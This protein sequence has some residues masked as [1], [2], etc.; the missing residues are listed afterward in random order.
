M[1]TA[2][3]PVRPRDPH[4]AVKHELLVRYLDAW[5][6]TV[7]HSARRVTYAEG[8]A[9][10]DVH[11]DGEGGSSVTALRVFGEFTDRLAGRQLAMV[12]V[13]EDHDRLRTLADQLAAVHQELGRP[14]ELSV[15]TIHGTCAEH[16]V[17][18]LTQ[19]GATGGPI[20]GYLDSHGAAAVPF[21][22]V[23]AIAAHPASEALITL[24]P[25]VLAQLAAGL[26]PTE[27]GDLLFGGSHWRGVADQPRQQRYP[28]LVTCYRESLSRAGLGSLVHVELVDDAGQAQLLVFASR[29]SKNL[30]RLKDALWAVDEYAGVRYR[31][32]RD[33]DHTLLDISLAPHLRPLRQALLD[34][35]A[36]Q[37]E[38]TVADLRRYTFAETIYR[39][40]D[41][42]RALGVLVS[43]GALSR[44]PEKGRLTADTLIGP[45]RA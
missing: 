9:G 32:P 36:E 19:A 10:S 23:A 12:L 43:A 42:V 15:H 21:H 13:E 20:L 29:S 34:R 44:H 25:E 39:A 6:P 31:D 40:Q 26:R 28:Y 18:A 45:G 38:C 14:A 41:A 1:P 27:T 22:A 16:L 24:D 8:Y 30:E 35:I 4:A 11:E 5:T 33:G 7:L 2:H 37:G 17:P 3:G